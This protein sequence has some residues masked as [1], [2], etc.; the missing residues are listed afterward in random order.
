M[1]RKTI[2]IIGLGRFGGTLAKQV[3]ALGHEVCG[4]D[5][6]EKV[7]QKLTPFITHSIV[8]DFSDEETI[9]SLHLQDFDVVVIA[10]GDDLKA[11]LLTAMVLKELQAPY[12]V[13]KASSDMESKLLER[14]GVDLV[15]FPEMN[16]ADRLAQMLTREYIV[17]YFQLSQD[18]GLVEMNTPAFMVGHT[19]EELSLR[20][21]YGIN[22]VAIKRHK[23]VMVPPN[24]KEPLTEEDMLILIGRNEDIT[25]LSQ[26]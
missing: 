21:R 15:I 11:K 10:I 4:I 2:G 3:A 18:I 16:M 9:R 20:S 13:A 5:I 7:V 23:S 24:P 14:V 1:K 6:D 17:D 12:V 19:L 25:K 26:L 22:I 8:A